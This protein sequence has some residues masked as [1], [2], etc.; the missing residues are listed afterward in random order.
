M[1]EE[2]RVFVQP[3]TGGRIELRVSPDSSVGSLKSAVAK[4]LKLSKDKIVLL[5]RNKQLTE[6]SLMDNNILEGSKL[7]LLPTVETGIT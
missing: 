5:H 4:R 2:R 3:T 1:A 7:T 6:G